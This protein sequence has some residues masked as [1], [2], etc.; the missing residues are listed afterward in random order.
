MSINAFLAKSL[1]VS[2]VVFPFSLISAITLSKSALSVIIVVYL[3]FFAAAR[4]IEGPPMSIFSIISS[5][6]A[7][8]K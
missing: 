3:K 5:S 2:S 8:L 6:L 7:P 4:I 1:L